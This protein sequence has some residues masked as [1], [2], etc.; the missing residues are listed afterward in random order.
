MTES[1]SRVHVPGLLCLTEPTGDPA[2]REGTE[3]EGTEGGKDGEESGLRV[4]KM[5]IKPAENEAEEGAEGAV[6]R[7]C[8]L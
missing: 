1:A 7:V 4:C 3:T 8:F 2:R 6:K 5:E